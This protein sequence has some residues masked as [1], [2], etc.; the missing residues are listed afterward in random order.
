MILAVLFIMWSICCLRFMSKEFRKPNSDWICTVATVIGEREYRYDEVS[1]EQMGAK[2][3]TIQYNAE[4]KIYRKC[5]FR[6]SWEMP[7]EKMIYIRYNP[8]HPGIFSEVKELKE[9]YWSVNKYNVIMWIIH[10]LTFGISGLVLLI[11]ELSL[12]GI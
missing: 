8:N 7:E 3:L 11:Y 12:I 2:E 9:Q 5:I 6:H 4:G 10:I 1:S